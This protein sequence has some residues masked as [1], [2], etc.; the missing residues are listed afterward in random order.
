MIK[1]L[2]TM[3]IEEKCLN[4]IKTRDDKSSANIIL[5]GAKLKSF[6]LRSGSRMSS[7]LLFNMAL[8]VLARATAK[9]KK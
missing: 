8:E 6:P 3:G 9:N 7:P 5:N 2:N 1:T 4:I